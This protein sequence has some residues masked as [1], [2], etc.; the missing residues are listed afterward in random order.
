[1]KQVLKGVYLYKKKIFTKN[2][3]PGKKVYN[4][5]LLKKNGFEYRE[6]NPFRS[7]LAAA[8]KKGLKH[9]PLNKDSNV[10]YLGAA[11]GTTLSHLSDIAVNG[12][13][14]GVDISGKTT[15]Q[16]LQLC[17]QR[18]NLLPLLEDANKPLKYKK[19]LENIKIDLLYQDISQKSQVEILLKNTELFVKKK[20]IIFFVL[21][22]KSISSIKNVKKMFFEEE[23]KIKKFFRILQRI[24]LKPYDKHHLFYALKRR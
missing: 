20:E 3:V 11:T 23:K 21:K 2:L 7:K 22:G 9:W 8:I 12:A 4:E 17:K 18:E 1:M 10:L 15:Q 5:K 19:Y 6:W 13:L 14:F 16:F 24:D